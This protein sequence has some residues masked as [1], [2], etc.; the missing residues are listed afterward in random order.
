MNVETYRCPECPLMAGVPVPEQAAKP[1][2]D[3][4][5]AVGEGNRLLSRVTMLKVHDG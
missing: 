4:C 1:D 3:L 2:L 5:I